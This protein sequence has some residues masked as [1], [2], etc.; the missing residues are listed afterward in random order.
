MKI[1]KKFYSFLWKSLI[2]VFLLLNISQTHAW[3]CLISGNM[4]SNTETKE[5]Y[6]AYFSPRYTSFP[7]STSHI[8]YIQPISQCHEN[9]SDIK[10]N[11]LTM[12]NFSTSDTIKIII[13]IISYLL[14][15]IVLPIV[16]IIKTLKKKKKNLSIQIITGFAQL[17]LL[18]VIFMGFI[19]LKSSLIHLF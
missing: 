17:I 19:F 8:N 18:L 14:I 2:T 5:D 6:I 3:F 4:Y 9:Y 1:S 15:L 16:I 7:L 12:K 13:N 10:D 11:I